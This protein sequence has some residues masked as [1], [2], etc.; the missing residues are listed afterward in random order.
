LYLHYIPKIREALG[1][2][3]AHRTRAEGRSMSVEEITAYALEGL[4]AP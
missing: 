3:P 4:T 2:G 1:P